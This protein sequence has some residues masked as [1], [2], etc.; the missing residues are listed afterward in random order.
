MEEIA[1]FY[2]LIGDLC[3][4]RVYPDFIPE[5][6]SGAD[7][8]WWPAMRYTVISGQVDGTNCYQQFRPR[9]QID[10]Y[11]NSPQERAQCVEQV[12][13]TLQEAEEI[14]CELKTSPIFSYD[15]ERKKYQA[16]IDYLIF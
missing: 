2:S 16:T 6:N 8:N 11:A 3:G 9:V 12:M 15:I 4:G 10:I 13:D 1:A 14:D 5:Q 7:P